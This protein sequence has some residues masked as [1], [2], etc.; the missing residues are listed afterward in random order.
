[1]KKSMSVVILT[2]LLLTGF[3]VLA[4][5]Q[6]STT[7]KAPSSPAM[8]GCP[9]MGNMQGMMKGMPQQMA[10]R[11]SLSPEEISARLTEKKAEL[12]LSDVQVKQVTD[13]I[14]SSEQKK[15]KDSM[16]GMMSQM[17]GGQMKCPCM[18]SATK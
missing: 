11:F 2:V 16:Q 18:Q 7:P 4:Q 6:P 13:L 5:S 15:I 14:A 3:T 17:P 9:M 12:G 10:D 8:N 1:M